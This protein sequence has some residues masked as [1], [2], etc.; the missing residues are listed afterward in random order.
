MR[1][2]FGALATILLLTIGFVL[3]FNRGDDKP[4]EDTKKV[5][6][7]V[8][9]AK[10]DSMVTLTTSGPVTS[11]DLHYS[12]KVS[13]SASERRLEVMNGYDNTVVATNSYPNTTAAYEAFLSA[14]AGQGFTKS[15][16][17]KIEDKRSVCV[18]GRQYTYELSEGSESVSNLWSVSCDKSG[19]LNGAPTTIRQLFE[20]QIPEYSKQIQPYKL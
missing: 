18:T 9:Y 13:V 3:V 16:E 15:K 20:K 19:T 14:L 6:Q 8:D 10:K 7:L 4:A 5:S 12:I 17:T 1:Y 2:V 11:D